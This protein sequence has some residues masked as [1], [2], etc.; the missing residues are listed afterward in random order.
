MT[1]ADWRREYAE[2]GLTEAD[3]GT[4][5]IRAFTAWLDAARI[6][7]LHEPNAMAVSTIA[8][9]GT[10]TSRMVLVKAVDLRGFVFYT[11]LRSAKATDLLARP[12]CSLLFPWHPLERQVRVDGHAELVDDAEADAYFATRPRE[13][14]LGAWA[15]PQSQSVPGRDFL[16][17]RYAAAVDR[18]EGVDP[19]PR[20]PHWGGFLVR[21]HRIEF[22]QGR[23]GR[24]H[25]RIRFDRTDANA[26]ATTRLA[27]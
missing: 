18:F 10:P 3:L 2:R 26:W 5:P 11:N 6:A 21:P 15:S 16:N 4:D 12:E 24:M 27:P 9:T 17:D 14:Q 23:P 22:W 25:D 7:G 20:P 8:P 1:I 19:V 13:S